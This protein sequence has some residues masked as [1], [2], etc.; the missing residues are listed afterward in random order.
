MDR[1]SFGVR[2]ALAVGWLGLRPDGVWAQVVADPWQ[3]Q[4]RRLSG[5]LCHRAS[6][7]RVGRAYLRAHPTE[8]RI[9]V[10][11]AGLTAGW[12]EDPAWLGQAGSQADE[13]RARLQAQVRADFAAR[14]TV[15]VRGW[16]LALSEARLFGLAA[17]SGA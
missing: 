5:V 15:S 13:L 4:A 16:V 17:L 2:A 7:E 10:L 6:A 12:G 9:E 14:R 11:V 1:R 8:A 3:R